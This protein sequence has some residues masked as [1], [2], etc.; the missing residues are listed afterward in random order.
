MLIQAHQADFVHGL[1]GSRHEHKKDRER[2][3]NRS[4]AQLGLHFQRNEEAVAEQRPHRS[5][6]IS[7]CAVDR[8]MAKTGQLRNFARRLQAGQNVC[9][10]AGKERSRIKK[11]GT[12]EHVQHGVMLVGQVLPRECPDFRKR[13]AVL[14]REYR[15]QIAGV[16]LPR[17]ILGK[18]LERRTGRGWQPGQESCGIV[19]RCRLD[20]SRRR[21]TERQCGR[22]KDCRHHFRHG[23]RHLFR[24]PFAKRPRLR[25]SI[26]GGRCSRRGAR[27]SSLQSQ[28]G[29]VAAG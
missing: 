12:A 24:P 8:L 27:R 26:A 28:R 6:E 15:I 18:R 17:R 10:S 13:G 20:T 22:Q 9:R 7:Q 19:G 5:L 2:P 14:A 3:V 4:A 1:A 11:I 16:L 29:I 23:H 25:H 21:R